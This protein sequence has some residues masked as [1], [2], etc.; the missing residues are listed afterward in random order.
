MSP[1]QPYAVAATATAAEKWLMKDPAHGE[2]MLAWGADMGDLAWAEALQTYY[3]LWESCHAV[4]PR[5]EQGWL[6]LPQ[7]A[8]ERCLTNDRRVFELSPHLGDKDRALFAMQQRLRQARSHDGPT[9]AVRIV[10]RAGR[11]IAS[12][13][14]PK[15]AGWKA[16]CVATASGLVALAYM[17]RAH[18]RARLRDARDALPQEL[19]RV[20]LAQELLR[21]SEREAVEQYVLGVAHGPNDSSV[22]VMRM[23]AVEADLE[24]LVQ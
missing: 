8:L 17:D 11:D 24:S 5:E 19:G 7:H 12:A 13:M 3:D 18:A 6:C 15:T 9:T 16:H 4:G 23:L 10:G 20:A 14:G 22:E 2:A 1:R 21:L